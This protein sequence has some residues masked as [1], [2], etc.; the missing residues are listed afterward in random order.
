MRPALRLLVLG[1]SGQV[2]RAL[3]ALHGS[4]T[5]REA[6]DPLGRTSAASLA[7]A[8]AT[9]IG[10]T[11]EAADLAHPAAFSEQLRAAISA[12]QPTHVIN[13]AAYTAV[14]RAE[15][16]PQLAQAIN[17]QAVEALGQ[18]CQAV[19]VPVIHLSTDYVFDGRKPLGQAHLPEDPVNPQGVY[20]R[21]KAAGER[22][23]LAATAGHPALVFRTSWVFSAHGSNFVK[24]MLALAEQR[25]E[26]RVVNDQHGA[27]TSA[28]WLAQSLLQVCASWPASQDAAAPRRGLFHLTASGQTTWHGFAQHLLAAARALAPQRPWRIQSDDQVLAVSTADYERS[29]QALGRTAPTAPR[30]MNSVLDNRSTLAHFALMSCS[31]GR[32]DWASQL[33]P[34]LQA[35]LTSTT[36]PHHLTPPN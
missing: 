12:H 10:L 34:V 15:Q 3:T 14:D 23:F 2:G 11:R 4:S 27:P 5:T 22:R 35:L 24:T 6:G 9:V 29:M 18:T 25:D 17:A 16:E 32:P 30:P 31:E 19:G 28:E 26:L 33:Q 13:A 36:S 1:A 7:T 20:G 21:T 8:T